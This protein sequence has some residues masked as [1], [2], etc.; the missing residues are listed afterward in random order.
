MTTSRGKIAGLACA[1]GVLFFGLMHG[2]ES[3]AQSEASAD[4]RAAC[5]P[6]VFRLCSS[7]IPNVERIVACL[8]KD[9]ARL[10]EKCRA[11]FNRQSTNVASRTPTRSLRAPAGGGWCDFGKTEQTGVQQMWATWCK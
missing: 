7:E 6:D 4:D 8:Q 3:L 2:T 10:S 11:V 5:T 1:A 9:K